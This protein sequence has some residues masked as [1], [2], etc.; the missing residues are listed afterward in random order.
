MGKPR[1]PSPKN[2]A[3]RVTF[4]DPVDEGPPLGNSRPP[5]LLTPRP[6]GEAPSDRQRAIQADQH[7]DGEEAWTPWWLK[8]RMKQRGKGDQGAPKGKGKKGKGKGKG[9]KK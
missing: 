1:T 7:R 8:R 5:V 4:R 3:G 6:P 2:R 9:K